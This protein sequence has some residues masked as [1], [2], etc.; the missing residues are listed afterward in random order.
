MLRFTRVQSWK[1]WLWTSF[2]QQPPANTLGVRLNFK[3]VFP[4]DTKRFDGGCREFVPFQNQPVRRIAEGK[5]L[6]PEILVQALNVRRLT[7][8]SFRTNY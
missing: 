2:A 6:P 5:L 3:W 8:S 4:L 1:R 7:S